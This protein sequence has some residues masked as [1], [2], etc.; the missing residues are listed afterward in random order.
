[1][2]VAIQQITALSGWLNARHVL[3][4]FG[5]RQRRKVRKS[6][7]AVAASLK[8]WFAVSKHAKLQGETMLK[9]CS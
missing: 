6:L 5:R 4:S 2:S 7:V 8:K 9:L 3:Y 1:M